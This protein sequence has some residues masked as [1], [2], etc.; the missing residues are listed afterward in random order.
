MKFL[1]YRSEQLAD[2][3]RER[4]QHGDLV[5]PLPGTRGW[6]Q[7]LGVSR[8]TLE[9]AIA[10][11][12]RERLIIVEPRG[13]RVNNDAI[14][15]AAPHT[16]HT[17]P[18]VVRLLFYG[19]DHPELAAELH[20]IFLLTARLQTRG[21]QV[22]VEQCTDV[23]LHAIARQRHRAHELF[24][25]VGLAPR[26]QRLFAESKQAAILHGSPAPGLDLPFVTADQA[27]AV[28]HA[29]QMLLRKGLSRL[30]LMIQRLV[31]PGIEESIASFR[32][33]CAAWPHQP[34]VGQPFLM[35]VES[36][37]ALIAARRFA[38]RITERCGAIVAGPVPVGLV[39]TALLE[40]RIAVP[41][42]V[43]LAAILPSPAAIQ[44]C[45][46]V[47]YYPMPQRLMAKTLADV[48][49]HYFESGTVPRVRKRLTLELVRAL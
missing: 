45:P 6:S 48:A 40:R 3:L 11:L 43:E 16:S 17:S 30:S 18:R 28:G 26:H 20:W 36:D 1:R 39:L 44:L 13:M 12:R 5:E 4:I 14:R 21:I 38:S 31:A 23:R 47:H 37:E 10:I 32:S 25:L 15:R 42:Q 22:H 24:C 7:E 2:Y 19:R 9:Q 29:T 27:G 49:D 8:K 33:A 35:P 34:V 46:P 41:G